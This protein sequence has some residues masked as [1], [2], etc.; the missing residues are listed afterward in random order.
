MRD[1]QEGKNAIKVQDGEDEG[2]RPED[3]DAQAGADDG[4]GSKACHIF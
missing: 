2:D 4:K 1:T 3:G